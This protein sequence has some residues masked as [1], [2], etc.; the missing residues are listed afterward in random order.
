[1]VPI[2]TLL[3]DLKRLVS[4]LFEDLLARAQQDDKIDAGLRE[5]F[6]QIEK[7]GRTA[8]AFEVW[9]ED[10][11]DQV[12]VAW[13]LACVFVRFMEDN[14]LIDE[15]W[16]AGK[17][18]RRKLAEDSYELYFREH[19]KHEEW[20]YFHFVFHEVGKIPAARELFA[21]GKTPLWAVS[22]S[23]DA[24]M[25][26][27]AFWREM[28]AETGNLKRSFEVEDGDT[29]F[30]GDLYQELSEKAKKKYALLQTPVFVEEFILDR[31]LNLAIDE[32]GLEKVRLIDPTC[33][34]GHFL[35]GAF[36]RLFRLW[37]KRESNEI[38]AAQRALDG[39]WGVDINPFA[40]AIARFR[41]IV[42]AVQACGIK[43]LKRSH[44]PGWKIHLATGD[45]L[46]FGSKPAYGGERVRLHRQGNL[47]E[48]PAIYAVEEAKAV[49]EILD[50]GYHVVVGNPPYITVKDKAQSE[51]YRGLYSTCHRQYSLGVPFTQRFWELSTHTAEA[52]G[53]TN[54][55]GYVGMITT[56]AFMKREFGKRLIEDFFP[57][58]D[59]THIIDTSR[60]GH[61]LAGHGTPTVILF[62]RN[63]KP[64][65]DTVRAVFGINGEPTSTPDATPGFV[66]QSILNHVD[67]ANAQDEY[68]STADVARTTFACHPW[69]IG[70]GGAAGLKERLDEEGERTLEDLMS[71]VGRTTHTGEDEAFR[72]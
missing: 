1:M 61:T 2:K 55:V 25:K 50:Q 23:G 68:T 19:R 44:A 37:M 3:P 40:V 67:V 59:L 14:H 10:Y 35:L 62:G 22:P 4:G 69:S 32:F 17:N 47:F 26:L 41:L 13:V 7:G 34:S 21:E 36:D 49:D 9:R 65:S 52:T 60:M 6:E 54:V 71:D 15:C 56:N 64:T 8:Q 18:E 46:L 42:A 20:Q 70:G 48:L 33:G 63:R 28:D 53:S 57:K 58:I 66:W 27:L 72:A 39:V 31:T 11:V 51:A 16:L 45:S 5:A 12:A 38:V 43:H 24:A 29:R 30:L